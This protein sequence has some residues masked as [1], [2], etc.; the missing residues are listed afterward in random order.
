MKTIEKLNINFWILAITAILLSGLMT[1]M[2]LHEFIIVGLLKQTSSYS[3][4][5]EG[6]TPWYYKT[7]ELYALINFIF[8]ILFL[9]F[10]SICI[11]AIFK[12]NENLLFIAYFSTLIL[13][14]VM[15]FTSYF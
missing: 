10:F 14:F 2:N 12:K 3:F 7:A 15:L 5:I 13:F 9:I 6:D 4:G 11:W 8:G 1:S